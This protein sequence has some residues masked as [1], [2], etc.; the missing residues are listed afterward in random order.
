M[1]ILASLIEQYNQGSSCSSYS[2][3]AYMCRSSYL[4]THYQH[5]VLKGSSAIRYRSNPFLPSR[6][7]FD[8]LHQSSQSILG[9]RKRDHS[10]G[11]VP[12][13]TVEPMSATW[14]M[15]TKG[16]ADSDDRLRPENY[17]SLQ[18]YY[19]SRESRL[20]YQFVL[21]G[22]QH[23]GYYDQNTYWPFPIRRSLR[24]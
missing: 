5:N 4:Y 2:S 22:T 18:A 7:I 6:S 17:A 21:R 12:I 11:A 3:L 13:L 23:F 16:I 1:H 9:T 10:S 24:R 20:V 19:G 15:S 8:T 14:T